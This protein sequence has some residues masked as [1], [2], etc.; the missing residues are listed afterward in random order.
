MIKLDGNTEI[1][2]FDGVTN[3]TVYIG[4]FGYLENATDSL[5]WREEEM[6]DMDKCECL[7]LKEIY[8]Q[9]GNQ[10]I[11]V[12]V[13]EPLA[14]LIYQCGNYDDGEWWQVGTLEGYA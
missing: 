1:V 4:G 13:E 3:S 7:T 2:R 8:E 9:L 6:A 5:I 10:M 14:G 12:F 11:T